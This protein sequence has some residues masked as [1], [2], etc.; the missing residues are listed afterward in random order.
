[1]VIV[2]G[3]G[4]IQLVNAQT[5]KMFGYPREEMKDH[6]VEMLLPERFKGSHGKHRAGYFSNPN[7]RPM[8]EGLELFGRRK[9]GVEFPVEISLS[10]IETEEGLLVSAAIRDISER[11]YIR[12]LE[13]KNREL[14]QFAYIASHD[15]QEPLDTISSFIMLLQDEFKDQ[16]SEDASEYIGYIKASSERLRLLITGLLE[17]SRLGKK[18]KLDLV[19]CNDLVGEVLMDMQ[20]SIQNKKAKIEVKKLPVIPSYPIEM[21]LLFQNLISNALKFQH[22]DSIPEVTISCQQDEKNFTFCIKDNGIGIDERYKE[23]VFA[24]FQRLH[25]DRFYKGSGIGLA[26]CKKIV[27]LHDGRIWLE[28]LPEQGAK[29]FFTIP[30]N[31]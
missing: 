5:E 6:S 3:R 20:S 28:S 11:K 31:K 2:N 22:V 12:E 14:E 21:R 9:D 13:S 18:S 1:M 24:I 30:A 10:P 27:E 23:K 26:H 19:D 29:F 25:S 17:Y 7:V 16:M 4:I 15:L 8:G